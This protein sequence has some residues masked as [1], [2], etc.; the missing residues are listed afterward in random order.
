MHNMQVCAESCP[1]GCMG[2]YYQDLFGELGGG[3]GGGGGGAISFPPYETSAT[4]TY[5]SC[6][7]VLRINFRTSI[8]Q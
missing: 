5:S 8:I 4:I 2:L 6:L 7:I 1:L 3:G